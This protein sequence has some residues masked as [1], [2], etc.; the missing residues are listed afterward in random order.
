MV[1]GEEP[2]VAGTNN[3]YRPR[4]ILGG[5]MVMLFCGALGAY[6]LLGSPTGRIADNR[7]AVGFVGV[8]GVLVGL[9]VMIRG[10]LS[11]RR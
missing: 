2:A 3:E 8:A 11:L 7:Y 5:L 4:N 9:Y 1:N 6:A 10:F